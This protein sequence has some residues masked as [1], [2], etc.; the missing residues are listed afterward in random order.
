MTTNELKKGT[1]VLLSNG[2]R[3]RLEDNKKGTIR[4]AT[5]FGIE[6]EIGSIYAHDIVA[7]IDPVTGFVRRD[8][9]HTAVQKALKY[10]IQ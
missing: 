5:V 3:A 1:E 2:W 6:T 9:E 10:A 4:M 8:I 7:R